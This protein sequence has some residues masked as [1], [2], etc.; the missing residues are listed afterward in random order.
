MAKKSDLTTPGTIAAPPEIGALVDKF[1]EHRETYHR[2]G[3]NETQLRQDFLDPLFLARGWDV[4]NR[5]GF[6]EAY[7]D[8]V[9]EQGLVVEKSEGPKHSNGRL[10]ATDARP[11]CSA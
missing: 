10:G 9:L 6:A 8:V 7:R 5:Q 3:Y 1:G 11:A 4:F 2:A